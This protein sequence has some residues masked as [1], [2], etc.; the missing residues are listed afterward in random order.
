MRLP[1]AREKRQ[2]FLA[3]RS[4]FAREIECSGD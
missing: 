3:V 1:L 4:F 2:R